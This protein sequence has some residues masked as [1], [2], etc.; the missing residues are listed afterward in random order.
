VSTKTNIYDFAVNK[1]DEGRY[2]MSNYTVIISEE[3]TTIKVAK[4]ILLSEGGFSLV[5]PYHSSNKG[6]LVKFTVDYSKQ[7]QS[8]FRQELLEEYT[9]SN[10]VK[11]SMHVDGFV[12]FSSVSGN[13]IRSGRDSIT[14]NPRGLGYMTSTLEDPVLTGPMV[15]LLIW[16]KNDYQQVEGT[17]NK[18]KTL[19]F[20]DNDI[21][22]N[23]SPTDSNSY[24]IKIFVLPS[25]MW[26]GVYEKNKNLYID[27]S[28]KFEGVP[29]TFTLRVLPLKNINSFIAIGIIKCN[30]H[31]SSRSGFVLAGPGAL[32]KEKTHITQSM[33]ACY[34]NEVSIEV[35]SGSLDYI[36]I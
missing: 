17:I 35:K 31:F 33:F 28:Y 19:C 34:P 15:S 7:E 29:T 21:Y 20:K 32:H 11:L 14:R 24:S 26:W 27:L 22:H 12:Q 9:A 25:Y 30:S 3:G 13:N 2:Y 10:Q 16:G 4:I 1:K 36:P 6:Y 18:S 5:S 8:I 23:A